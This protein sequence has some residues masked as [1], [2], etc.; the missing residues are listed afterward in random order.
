[1]RA[2]TRSVTGLLVGAGRAASKD[3]VVR[4]EPP[5][6]PVPQW[7]DGSACGAETTAS[8]MA[9]SERGTGTVVSGR[10]CP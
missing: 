10:P 8:P 4:V 1:M 7:T 3:P 5:G 6:M 9:R 2:A